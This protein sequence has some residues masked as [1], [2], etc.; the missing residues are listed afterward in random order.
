[1]HPIFRNSPAGP[2][3][4]SL[5]GFE[6]EFAAICEQHRAERRAL[7]FAFLLYDFTSPQVP[8]VLQDRA[9]WKALDVISGKYLSVFFFHARQLLEGQADVGREWIMEIDSDPVDD[10]NAL[11]FRHFRLDRSPRVPCIIFFQVDGGVIADTY[12]VELHSE[13]KEDFFL[14]LKRVIHLAVESVSKVTAENYEN[15][16][17]VFAL[18]RGRLQE[19]Q[20]G[21][22]I[23]RAVE[24]IRSLKDLLS[25]VGVG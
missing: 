13:R 9:L 11:A 22:T 12:I 21:V 19:R 7:A 23:L 8:H 17:E 25:M 16:G 20:L 6:H 2:R 18:M 10:V 15:T 1:M 4:L 5:D 14:E 24:R 3:G